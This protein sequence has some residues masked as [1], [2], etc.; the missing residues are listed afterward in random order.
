[1]TWKAWIALAACGVAQAVVAADVAPRVVP[2]VVPAPQTMPD[3]PLG[4][5]VRQGLSDPERDR[6]R[7]ARQRRQRPQLLV[8][9]PERRDDRERL[10]ARRAVGRVSRVLR[11]ERSRRDARGSHQRLLPPLDE[12]QADRRRRCADAR[13]DGVCRMAVDRR[14]DR[15]ERRGPRI[16]LRCPRRR[17]RPT[18]ARGRDVLRAALR[19]V[20]RT[21]RRRLAARE[22]PT[23]CRRYGDRSRSTTAPACRTSRRPRRSSRPRCRSDAAARCPIR[24]V[25]HRGAGHRRAAAR[26]TRARPSDYPRAGPPSRSE[27]TLQ[28]RWAKSPRWRVSSLT[29]LGAPGR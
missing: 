8:V 7:L 27:T 13:A 14:A 10:A 12:R 9:P 6:A 21:G 11:A 24:R 20:P 3:G 17:A 26:R 28:S 18:Q 19:V 25:G 29:L 22:A 16:P 15:R 23:R 2:F 5:A 4:D 1:M